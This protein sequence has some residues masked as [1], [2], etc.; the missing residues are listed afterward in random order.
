MTIERTYVQY[1]SD[2]EGHKFDLGRR[3]CNE[4]QKGGRETER[5]ER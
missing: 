4:K 2:S 3:E 1:Y 5:K